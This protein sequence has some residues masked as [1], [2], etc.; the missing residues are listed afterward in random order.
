MNFTAR[1]TASETTYDRFRPF[2]TRQAGI[3]ARNR[4]R[5][6]NHAGLRAYALKRPS[7]GKVRKIEK[8]VAVSRGY[9]CLMSLKRTKPVVGCLGCCCCWSCGKV[10]CLF[11]I[12]K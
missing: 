11:K 7:L 2:Q 6:L 3:V 5:D 1:P 8:L 4:C 9:T 12:L 10:H